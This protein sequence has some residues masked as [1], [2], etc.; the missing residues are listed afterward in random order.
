MKY[1]YTLLLLFCLISSQLYSQKWVKTTVQ[2]R[3]VVLEEF[4]GI[5]CGYCPDG[6]KIAND[7]VKSNPGKVFLVNVHAG[8]YAVPQA[9]EP[10]LRTTE[11]TAIDAAAK[12]S[13]YPMGS[14]SR[15]GSPFA[16]S[17]N[18]WASTASSLLANPSPVNVYVKSSIDEKLM[19]L[20]TEVEIYYTNASAQAKNYLTIALTQDDILGPQSDYGNYNP[21]NWT[22]DG[23]YRHNHVL[24]KILTSGGANGESIDTTTKNHY[25]Y[26]KYTTQLP[27]QINKIDLVW[28]KLNVVAFVTESQINGNVLSG[29]GAP[30]DYD[31]NLKVDLALKNLTVMPTDFCITSI[32]PKA[33]ITNNSG[34]DI[35][36]FDVS[37]ILNGIENKK[38]YTGNFAKGAKTIL[39]WGTIPF[40]GRGYYTFALLGS[41]NVASTSNLLQDMDNTNDGISLNG[42]GFTSKAFTNFVAGFNGSMPKDCA[43]DLSQNSKF[44]IVTGT[45]ANATNGAIRFP[46]HS[47]WGLEGKP[48]Y[49]VIGELDLSKA[50]TPNLFYYYA[51]SD[52]NMNGTAPDIRVSVSEDCGATWKEINSMKCVQTGLPS[53]AGNFYVPPTIDYKKVSVSLLAYAGKGILVRVAGVAGTTGNALYID[54]ITTDLTTGIEEDLANNTNGVYPNPSTNQI[55]LT[56]PSLINLNYSIYSSTGRLIS[57]GLN[58]NNIFDISKFSNG[59]YY[60]KINSNEFKFVKN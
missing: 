40:S 25:E 17:R 26:R 48:G 14:V 49:I 50:K 5:H 39:D 12:P 33:E 45:G 15:T 19:V 46:L 54:E 13:G 2:N 24:R 30:V 51:Y 41:Q 3:N 1:I 4:T 43:F 16:L 23:K 22:T 32:S 58:I 28:Y 8:G 35:A 59:A 34:M 57:E 10:D 53:V 7:M 60:V 6:H 42:M 20:T 11:G 55:T 21:T 9:G 47:T 36:S 38:S 44:A 56:N 18:L 37:L 31:P 27:A 29:M 52:D